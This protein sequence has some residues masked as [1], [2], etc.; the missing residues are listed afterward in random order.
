MREPTMRRLGVSL[1]LAAFAAT[2]VPASAW[3]ARP[4]P[5]EAAPSSTGSWIVTFKPG[6]KASAHAQ[7]LAEAA[8]GQAGL[9]YGHALNGFVFK[10]SNQ[11]A[12]A[13]LRNPNVRT[14]VPDGEIKIAGDGIP[15]GVGRIAAY[16]PT[17]P[18]SYEAGF[19]GAGTRIAILDTGIDLTHP[20]LAASLDLGL[21]LNCMTDPPGSAPPQ[22]GHG[23]GTHVAGI[24][25]APVNGVGVIGVAPEARIVPIKVLDD[26]GY[27]EWSNLICGIDYLTGLNT[28]GDPSNDVQVANMSLGDTGGI[29]TCT[30]GFVREAICTSVAAGITYVAAAGNSTVDTSTF[31]PAAMPEVIAVSAL[32]DLDGLPG[33]LAGCLIPY[34]NLFCDDTL[35]EFSN[36][37][38][39]VDLTAPGFQIYSDW[40]GGGYQS[41]SGTSMASPHVAGVALLVLAENPALSPADVRD[42]LKETGECANGTFADANGTGDCAGQGQWLHD[43]DGYGEPVVNALHAASAASGWAPKPTITI[44]NPGDGSTVSGTV[45]VTADAASAVGLASVTF[46]INGMDATTDTDGSD[47]WTFGWDTS[48]LDDGVYTISATATDTIG[49]SRTAHVSVQVGANL[50][51][52]WVGVYGADG[53]VI[54]A[55]NGSSDLVGLPSGVT[56]TLEQG[57]RYTWQYAG[58]IRALESPSESERRSTGWYHASEV[59]VRLDFTSAYSGT[60]H[61]YTVDWGAANRR[62]DVTVDD[63]AGPL[64]ASLTSD[65][66][67]GAWMHFPINVDAGGSVVITADFRS[68]A[69]TNAVLEGLFLGGAGEAVPPPPSP[70]IEIPGVQGDW[71]GVYGADGYVIGA[72]NGSS[73]LVGLPSGVTYTLEQGLRYTWQYAGDIRALESPSESERRSTGWYHASEVRVRLDFT[74]AYSGTLHLYT[75]DWG[76]ANRRED[77]TV[78]DGA[79]PL[80]ASLTSDFSNGAWMHFPINVDAGGS[81]VI[82]ADFRS[83]AATNAVLEGLFLGGAGEAVPPPPSPTIEIPGVQGDWVGVYGA[84]GYVIGAWNGSSDLVGLPSGVTYTLEQGLRYTWQYAGDIRALESPSESERRS[85]GW[86]HASEVRVRLDFTSAYSGTLH[87]YTVDWGAANRREDVTVDDGAGPLTASL[88]SDFSNG[89]W[90]HFPINVDAGG[91]VVITADF[92]SGAATNAVLE[93]LFL[94]GAGEAVPP[95]PTGL[96]ATPGNGQVGLTWSAPASDGGS[97]ITSYTATASPGGASCTTASLGCTVSGLTNG[98]TYSFTVVATNGVGDSLPSGS[99]NASPV[100]PATVPGAPTGLAATPGNGQ[101]GLTWSAPASDGGSPITSYTATASP[102]GA[103]CTTASLG[104]TVSG[105]T[106]GQTYSFTVVATNGVGDSLPSG[107]V[108]ASP[109]APATVPGAPTGLAATPGNGQV[110]LTWSAPASD[111]GSPITSYTA[112]AS[113][114]G[115]SCTTASLGCTVSGLTNGQTYSF[116]VVA[117]NGVGDSLPSGSVNASPVAPATVPGAPT[118]LAATPGNGQV[119]LT[120]SAPASDGGSPITSYTATAS[121]GGASCTTASLGCTV[122]GL[123]NGQTYSFTV[124]ATNGVGDSLPSG[125]VNASPVAPATVPGAPTGLAATALRPSGIRLTW[126]APASS[127]GSP[128]LGY[129]IYRSTSSGAEV[130]LATVGNVTTYTDNGTASHTRYYY[131]VAA[132]NAVGPGALSAEVNARAR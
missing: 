128:I 42:L 38:P 74:S 97:P 67:N 26:T 118:G 44:T 112:T 93:G 7:A 33:G 20:D 94:G 75:V 68:G 106:N 24:A 5:A 102:G 11:A 19:R 82:T 27:G 88:T 119:G 53:Y 36:F 104:C 35:A 10:G 100:A 84:D 131:K 127:G 107:S 98:Q 77:V 17:T 2:L 79:G 108:N 34:F 52:D 123:T 110:G 18:D 43:P 101:V 116:T 51:G 56:Y 121:P 37:G 21:G 81:V 14:V 69:A 46:A 87:L 66:S 63:G 50:Q 111:G 16:S 57:L 48:G 99:V 47:G 49:Q 115:A 80:T 129:R 54:G 96:A 60:L 89:A 73:D 31:I 109:V 41:E 76:A 62:E 64:T 15:T 120:W 61:L 8:G 114:G 3:A 124:V 130:L 85:T 132:V 13:L 113:P 65:F 23:H 90:M 92:R 126:S 1:L 117:T 30:D 22:D 86:Y 83:G 55:W 6:V 25:A 9:V 72:W 91:S 103:S 71:V 29:G 12:S 58:D 78:D 125:S 40:T 59:R 39:D 105:L 70:T 122:S 45:T 95:P 4:A 28:D 32:T